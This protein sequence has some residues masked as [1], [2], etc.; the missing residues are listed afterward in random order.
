MCKIQKESYWRSWL[1]RDRFAVETFGRGVGHVLLV[2]DVGRF[3]LIFKRPDGV[4][5]RFEVAKAQTFGVFGHLHKDMMEVVLRNLALGDEVAEKRERRRWRSIEH[6]Y[7][8][9]VGADV[10][11]DRNDGIV[12]RTKSFVIHAG[13]DPGFHGVQDGL[14]QE[15]VVGQAEVFDLFSDA[16]NDLHEDTEVR[17]LRADGDGDGRHQC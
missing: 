11:H 4:R 9:A 2:D 14:E 8:V 13:T 3:H 1:R 6:C 10:V 15:K 16:R 12:E 17:N 5:E 7:H